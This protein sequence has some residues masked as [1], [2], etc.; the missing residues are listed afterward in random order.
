MST[1]FNKKNKRKMA[2]DRE[3]K[4]IGRSNSSRTG[5]DHDRGP[6]RGPSRAFPW[7]GPTVGRFS[8]H[9]KMDRADLSRADPWTGPNWIVDRGPDRPR[10]DPRTVV[11]M[12]K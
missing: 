7:S 12:L 9:P 5:P 1:G 8:L 6:D 10:P 2:V 11:L 3:L 4:W